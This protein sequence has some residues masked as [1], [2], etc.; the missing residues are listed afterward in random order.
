MTPTAL[1]VLREVEAFLYL[2]ARLADESD[3]EGWEALWADDGVYW[4]PANGTD[5]DPATTM[6]IIFDNRSRIATRVRQLQTGK[7]YAQ[8]PVSRL[9][10][11]VTNVEL[12]GEDD[13]DLLVGANVVVYESRD[14]GVTL[15]PG[16]AE[17]R[18]RRDPGPGPGWRMAR[19]KVVLVDN[20]RALDTLGFLI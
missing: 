3:Y 9:R 10:R 2:E 15:W 5:P 20:D 7:R 8:A 11:F 14:R 18:L 16:R 19:K 12:L 6:S 13:G 17:Y 4:V 1:D